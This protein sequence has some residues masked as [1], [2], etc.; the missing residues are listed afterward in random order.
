MYVLLTIFAFLFI[1]I[2]V[3][4]F[5]FFYFR[6]DSNNGSID[7]VPEPIQDPV[8]LIPGLGGSI[9]EAKWDIK[10][11][12]RFYC[13]TKET[14]W[15]QI[16]PSIFS[17]IPFE[18]ICW[19]N[20]IK[21]E[22]DG[23]HIKSSKG[24]QTRAKDFGG[25]KGINILDQVDLYL[26]NVP[27]VKY[28]EET[29]KKLKSLGYNNLYGAPY[30]FRLILD[31]D[32]LKNYNIRLK[33]LIEE[34]WDKSGKRKVTLI[35]HSLGG[36]VTSYFINSHTK[37]WK[38][39]YLKKFIAI[40]GPFGGATESLSACL[41]GET[42]GIPVSKLFMKKLERDY[43]GVIWMLNE[44]NTWRDIPIINGKGT[45]YIP[46]AMEEAGTPLSG[47]LW[48]NRALSVWPQTLRN[49]GLEMHLVYGTK[50]K[51]LF[52]L[53][54]PNLDFKNP[55]Y[56]YE[57]EGDGTVPGISLES[58]IYTHG[59]NVTSVHKLSGATHLGILN[60]K[61]WLNLIEDLMK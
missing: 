8:I 45:N 39:K 6:K 21:T 2:L 57:N 56:T 40:S 3:A 44:P 34:A 48:E 31:Q 23:N 1:A 12:P 17:A 53:N 51:T 58:P 10:D 27:I 35:S 29:S 13:Q 33:K 25:L 46:K 28:F 7:P 43:A 54:Y 24:V 5:V 38:D 61:R 42:A 41:T 26:L 49:P 11:S 47:K 59:W 15:A 30:D 52:S 55:S 22:T 37:A 36:P 50:V 4:V 20:L 16:W 18:N 14:D 32:Y 60:D 19:A 9:L